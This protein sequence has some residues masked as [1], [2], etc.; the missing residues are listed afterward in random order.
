MVY[1]AKVSSSITI[2]KKNEEVRL[3]EF[4]VKVDGFSDKKLLESAKEKY[5][6]RKAIKKPY[7]SEEWPK[8]TWYSLYYDML[9]KLLRWKK[10]AYS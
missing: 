6:S 5:N 7:Y 3:N 9:K 4:D 1:S 10:R 8:G 2:N